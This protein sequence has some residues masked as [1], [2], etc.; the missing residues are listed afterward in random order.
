MTPIIEP[1]CA[2]R[3][4]YEVDDDGVVTSRPPRVRHTAEAWAEVRDG[5]GELHPGWTLR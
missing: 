1:L 5:I 3:W 2:F 4:G